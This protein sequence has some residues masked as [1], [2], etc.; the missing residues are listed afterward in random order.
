MSSVLRGDHAAV[1]VVGG[2]L[3]PVLVA[4]FA[5]GFALLGGISLLPFVGPV[6]W[7]AA[8]IVAVGVALVSRFGVPR[9]RVVF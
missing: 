7:S 8:S 3:V 9:Y 2:P 5:A 1:I 4:T 6:L